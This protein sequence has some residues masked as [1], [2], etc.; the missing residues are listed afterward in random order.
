MLI[1]NCF[2]VSL[3]Y[4]G[5]FF[6]FFFSQGNWYVAPSCLGQGSP[7]RAEFTPPR[8]GC[9]MAKQD[10]RCI[11]KEQ[12]RRRPYIRSVHTSVLLIIP[13]ISLPTADERGAE[14]ATLPGASRGRSATPPGVLVHAVNKCRV[15]AYCQWVHYH[16]SVHTAWL[17]CR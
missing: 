11:F 9:W 8:T 3:F 5:G 4:C 13:L 7:H 2:F 12:Q 16:P 1:Q 14:G 6:M 15:W 17:S 10:V